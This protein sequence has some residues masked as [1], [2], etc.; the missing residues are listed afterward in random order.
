MRAPKS[1]VVVHLVWATWDRL[2]WITPE[3]EPRLHACLA[4]EA[5]GLR[6]VPIA[7]GGVD[8]HVHVLL[9]VHP[10]IAV[11]KLVQQLKGSSSHVINKEIAPG[12]DFRWQ[13][14]YGAFSLSPGDVASV[15]QY[16]ARQKEHHARHNVIPDWECD[17]DQ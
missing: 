2:P 10:T 7:V 1:A 14:A 4:D 9:T 13:G 17:D 6:C 15:T 5:R 3:I 16:V 8:D 11:A 12:F